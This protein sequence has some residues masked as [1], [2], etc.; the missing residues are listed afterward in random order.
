EHE[1]AALD[2][3]EVELAGGRPPVALDDLVA[4]RAQAALG[5]ILGRAALL[6]GARSLPFPP[7]CVRHGSDVG[8]AAGRMSR[9]R[10]RAAGG[11]ASVRR[12]SRRPAT[13]PPWP[14]CCGRPSP[15]C[16][17]PPSRPSPPCWCGWPSCPC[18]PGSWS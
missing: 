7:R 8:R 17:P 5:A 1:V 18:G 16:E 10:W 2:G 3:D 12:V 4:E 13:R 11:D 6:G 14:S 9:R 15:S